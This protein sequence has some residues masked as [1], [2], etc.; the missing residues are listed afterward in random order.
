MIRSQ[1][2]L[3][4]GISAASYNADAKDKKRAAPKLL[5]KSAQP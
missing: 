5:L 1:K 2:A 4:A 3:A